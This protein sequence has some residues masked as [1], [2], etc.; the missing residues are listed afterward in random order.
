MHPY[1]KHLLE[2]IKNAKRAK[3]DSLGYKKPTTFEEEMEE[4]E[5]YVSGEGEKPVSAFTGLNKE[6]F[7][8]SEQLTDDEMEIVLTAYDKML[9]T[10]NTQIDWRD[11][12]PIKAKY[13]FLL[14]FVLNHRV[15]PL[16]GGMMHL[17]FC[18]GY[19]PD[20]DW[21]EYCPCKETWD[22]FQS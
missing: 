7:P 18:T 8:P 12:M 9:A 16:Y 2:D 11:N 10:W 6:N 3:N 21:G 14:K 5:R 1:I 17:D 19:A 13:D 15:T 22:D 4:I 20:C